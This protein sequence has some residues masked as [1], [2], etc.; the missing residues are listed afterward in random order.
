MYEL[1][2]LDASFVPWWLL[3]IGVL[4]PP[5]VF[6]LA[7]VIGRRQGVL[8]KA[9][10]L[11]VGL[12]IVAGLSLGVIA[13][14][15]GHAARV[16]GRNQLDNRE[17]FGPPAPLPAAEVATSVGVW[18]E[19]STFL[20]ISDDNRIVTWQLRCHVAGKVTSL[21]KSAGL[22][23][24]SKDRSVAKPIVLIA[25]ELSPATVDALGPDFDVGTVTAPTAPRCWPRWPTPAPSSF[26]LRR[27]STPKRSP[28]ASSSR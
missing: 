23:P 13:S 27:T 3:W 28:L 14:R 2:G 4:I 19:A 12:T 6:G 10:I 9:L 21:R 26:G 25:E 15:A 22:P 8:G 11:L 16:A 20:A 7:L 18:G 17:S 24:N 1:Y 5:L